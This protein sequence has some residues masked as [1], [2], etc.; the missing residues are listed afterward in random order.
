MGC[1]TRPRCHG[2]RAADEST[3][4]FSDV[5]HSSQSKLIKAI[6][7]DGLGAA[8]SPAFSGAAP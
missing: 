3:R 2:V 8:R 4:S 7:D 1:F 5:D 6:G